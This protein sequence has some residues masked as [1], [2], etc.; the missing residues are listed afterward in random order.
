MKRRTFFGGFSIGAIG[1]SYNLIKSIINRDNGNDEESEHYYDPPWNKYKQNFKSLEHIEPYGNKDLQIH[2]INVGQADATLIITPSDKTVLIDTGHSLDNGHI[3]YSYLQAYSIKKIDYLILT[4]PHWD[5][6]GGTKKIVK[7]YMRNMNDIGEILETGI[8]HETITYKENKDALKKHTEKISLIHEYKTLDI[9]EDIKINIL[10][11][12]KDFDKNERMNN[13]SVAIHITHK[14]NRILLPSDIEKEAEKRIK[15]KYRD[16]L[17]SDIYR[18]AH[19]GDKNSSTE[20]FL[21]IVNPEYAIISSPY[22]SE[23]NHPHEPTLDRLSERDIE[24]YWTAIHGSI[25]TVSDGYEW[26]IFCQSNSTTEP[27]KLRTESK[28]TSYPSSGVKIN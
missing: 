5:H 24:T 13:N 26:D 28:I 27:D 19:H 2:H 18:T 7:E 17:S 12:K 10:N 14:N 21:D 16:E 9:D 6:I 3:V 15:N 20:E 22:D 23:W 25:I 1:L 4:H 11:P 8:S